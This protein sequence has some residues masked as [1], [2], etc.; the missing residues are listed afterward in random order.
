MTAETDITRLHA[1]L[2][3]FVGRT[4]ASPR[5]ADDPVNLPMIRHWC[6]AMGD[7]N[8]VYTSRQDAI[9]A[10]FADIVAPP[11]MLQSWTH[12]DRRFDVPEL[13][14]DDGEEILARLLNE[15]GYP[16]VVATAC[17]AEYVRYLVPGD[18]L[19]YH[20]VIE[21]ISEPKTTK[22]GTGFFITTL[23][24]YTDQ[25]DEVVGTLRFVVFRFRPS[26]KD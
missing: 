2:L 10:G 24:S 14:D 12:H 9:D 16:S 26:D 23:V 18:L 11:T 4:G 20:C 21:S 22:L 19:T 15:A 3:A 5:R 8:P 6:Q 25:N 17:E 7:N 1:E 13:S